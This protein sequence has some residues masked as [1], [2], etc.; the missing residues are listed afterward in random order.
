MAGV[1]QTKVTGKW[2][3]VTLSDELLL[4]SI[5]IEHVFVP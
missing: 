3:K 4:N 2:I 1:E 5:Y